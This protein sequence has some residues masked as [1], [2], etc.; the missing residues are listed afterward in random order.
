MTEND[1]TPEHL[2]ADGIACTLTEEEAQRRRQRATS[3]LLPHLEATESRDDGAVLTFGGTDE[4]VAAAMEFVRNE[5][6]CCSFAHFEI[7]IP[8]RSEPIR[9]TISGEGADAMFEQ[10]IKPLVAEYDPELVA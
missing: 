7:E 2:D 10:G 5:R 9:V 8:P 6:Q 1:S 4:A 3:E